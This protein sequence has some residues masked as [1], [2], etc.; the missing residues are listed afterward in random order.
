MAQP[1]KSNVP[2][3]GLS[4]EAIGQYEMSHC[5]HL[6]DMKQQK[7][8]RIEKKTISSEGA[9]LFCVLT[10]TCHPV[11]YSTRDVTYIATQ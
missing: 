10:P 8:K 6:V 7:G 5:R 9:G 4:I 11:T 3:I 1:I 2:T